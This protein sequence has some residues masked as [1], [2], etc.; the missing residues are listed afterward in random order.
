[1]IRDAMIEERNQ[2]EEALALNRSDL[3]VFAGNPNVVS[4]GQR[5]RAHRV[6]GSMMWGDN[7]AWLC[8][9]GLWAQEQRGYVITNE[10][11]SCHYCMKK[12]GVISK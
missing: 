11:I 7:R 12:L 2:L 10:K 9:C 8:A 3:S 5:P 6:F 4:R 1:M